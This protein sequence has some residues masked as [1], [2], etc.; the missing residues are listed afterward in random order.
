MF[1]RYERNPILTPKE[2]NEWESKATFN[3]AALYLDGVVHVL[4]RGIGEYDDYISKLGYARFRLEGGEL[5]LERREREPVYFSGGW[6][7]EDPR[8][9][10]IEDKIYVTYVKPL[11]SPRRG[12][13]PRSMLVSTKDFKD[14]EVHGFITPPLAE[15]KDVVL[16]PEKI[17]GKYVMVHR[18]T[19]WI[20]SSV[21]KEKEKL[22]VKY[23]GEFVDWLEEMEIPDYFPEKPSIWIAF[24]NDLKNF[25]EDKVLLEPAEDWESIKVGAGPPPL[26]TEEGWL[27][28]YHGVGELPKNERKIKRFDGR[29]QNV[30]Y[31][32]GAALLDLKDPSYV[33][34]KSTVPIL[35][36]EKEYEMFGDVPFVVFPTGA[37]VHEGKIYLFYGAA[38]KVCCL[39]ICELDELLNFLLEKGKLTKR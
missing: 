25:K 23:G 19:N 14:F 36:P 10:K 15:D 4:Y 11:I 6:G 18:P 26:K 29:I 39:A 21:R 24:S 5:N 3:C 34:A 2:D 33:I 1:E 9:V 16:F 17:K 30:I 22:K 20:K 8:M 38:D 31:R 13:K 7:C 27:L 37:F 35:Q 12:G 28:I 32:V